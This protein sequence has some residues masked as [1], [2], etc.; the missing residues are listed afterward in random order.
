MNFSDIFVKILEMSAVSSVIAIIVICL[1]KLAGRVIPKGVIFAL[2]SVV[3]LKLLIPVSIPSPVSLYNVVDIDGVPAFESVMTDN[4]VNISPELPEVTLPL[5]EA[6]TGQVTPIIPSVPSSDIPV[7]PSVPV[8][9]GAVQSPV[10]PSTP[11][12]GTTPIQGDTPSPGMVL[13]EQ[14][15]ED[16]RTDYLGI[17]CRVYAVTAVALAALII[18]AYAFTAYNIGK[19]ETVFDERIDDILGRLP[20]GKRI[21]VKLF[22]GQRSIMIFGILRP[23]VVLPEDYNSLSDTEL[24]YLLMHE[25]Q[26]YRHFDTLWNLLMLIACAIHWFNPFVWISRRLFL[27][28]METACDARVLRGLPENEKSV[29]AEVLV[30]FAS[31]SSRDRTI[32]AMGF[33]KRNVKE[34]VLSIMKYKRT[35]VITAIAS[36][37][38]LAVVVS[39]FATGAFNET[40]DDVPV[41]DITNDEVTDPEKTDSANTEPEES[42]SE[43]T[44]AVTEPEVEPELVPVSVTVTDK[45]TFRTELS[46]LAEKMKLSEKNEEK[47]AMEFSDIADFKLIVTMTKDGDG[48][49]VALSEVQ[50][51]GESYEIDFSEVSKKYP[52]AVL[53]VVSA[54]DFV[55]VGMRNSL[56]TY[57]VF[58]DGGFSLFEMTDDAGYYVWSDSNSLCYMKQNL[59]FERISEGIHVFSGAYSS[60]EQFYMDYGKIVS[61]TEGT[62]NVTKTEWTVQDYFMS[63]SFVMK[64][65]RDRYT[66]DSVDEFVADYKEGKLGGEEVLLYPLPST[67]TEGEIPPSSQPSLE[68]S[69]KY[70]VLHVDASSE[71]FKK[72]FPDNITSE[73]SE[74]IVADYANLKALVAGLDSVSNETYD[75]S[76][77]GM[78][79]PVKHTNILTTY[80]ESFFNEKALVAVYI[81]APNMNDIF[82]V[83]DMGFEGKKLS[84]SIQ[85]RNGGNVV[86]PMMEHRLYLVELDREVILYAD[87]IQVKKIPRETIPTIGSAMYQDYIAL[88]SDSRFFEDRSEN[89]ASD[90]PDLITIKDLNELDTFLADLSSAADDENGRS[91][92]EG[93]RESLLHLFK[94]EYFDEKLLCIVFVPDLQ[95]GEMFSLVG[96]SYS[97]GDIHL[98]VRKKVPYITGLADTKQMLLIITLNKAAVDYSDGISVTFDDTTERIYYNYT[99]EHIDESMLDIEY[100]WSCAS[101]SD[102]NGKKDHYPIVV[103]NSY[104]KLVEFLD[105]AADKIGLKTYNMLT[106]VY[107]EGYFKDNVL[108]L[109]CWEEHS[110]IGYHAF[111]ESNMEYLK[112]GGQEYLIRFNLSDD[113]YYLV[114]EHSH[115]YAVSVSSFSKDRIEKDNFMGFSW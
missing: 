90:G 83:T 4:E 99:P 5:V 49:S 89:K 71:Y 109:S 1:R 72:V 105:G 57:Y 11:I 6:P 28:D 114:D 33:G 24:T 92:Y 20:R 101:N 26:H 13:T 70:H 41:A 10:V 81:C 30:S 54:G 35:G 62:L 15:N 48:A 46:A 36:F 2:W 69:L 73:Y 102:D 45:N 88:R 115:L 87:D 53:D 38:I 78:S 14:N 66:Y 111:V 98:T 19:S 23:A 103:I 8:T 29:F 93:L 44:E 100:Y 61:F 76:F 94:K 77:T 52:N 27:C 16:V 75:D 58:T 3:I 55:A 21:R 96:E 34:R 80:D 97:G 85:G 79:G 60:P 110:G 37:V 68:Y 47:A 64:A 32:V 59:A 84:V 108:I 40:S 7:L 104:D 12:E 17:V 18:F 50:Y 74:A 25:Y 56:G 67:G 106:T 42:T 112:D 107:E 86:F 63:D 43:S 9:D 31:R 22:R 91:H 39:V 95:L 65:E 113:K 51:K 82:S